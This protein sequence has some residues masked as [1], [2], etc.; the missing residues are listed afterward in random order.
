M[1][2]QAGS[3]AA[4]WDWEARH[5]ATAAASQAGA[6]TAPWGDGDAADVMSHPGPRGAHGHH[7]PGA[8]GVLRARP[9]RVACEQE[10]YP[11]GG[12]AGWR[13]VDAHHA[14]AL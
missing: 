2:D 7:G 1:W 9:T 13:T 6:P 12:P 5:A 14:Q 8:P 11:S 3:R 4:L 10:Q